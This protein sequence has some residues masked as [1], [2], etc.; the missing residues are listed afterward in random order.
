M[1]G[2]L[3]DLLA[4]RTLVKRYRIQ[5]VIGRGGFAVVYCADDLRLGRPTA[6]KVLAIPAPTP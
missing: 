1:A 5:E 3:E 4:G 6:V 2:G